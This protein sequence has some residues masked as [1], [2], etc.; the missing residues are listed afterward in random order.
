MITR[1]IKATSNHRKYVSTERQKV[2]KK[3]KSIK[4][5]FIKN[6]SA[7]PIEPGA[8]PRNP[9]EIRLFKQRI[10]QASI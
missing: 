8:M 3:G 6:G 5:R 10:N 4:L 2:N 7:L 1:H 9:Q